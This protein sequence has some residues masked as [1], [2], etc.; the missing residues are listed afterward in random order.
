MLSDSTRLAIL[1]RLTQGERDFTMLARMPWNRAEPG[2]TECPAEPPH[3]GAR[4]THGRGP[5]WR[6]GI[7]GAPVR[8]DRRPLEKAPQETFPTGQSPDSLT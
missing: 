8:G 2:M 3:P 6:L 5:S 7:A 4:R 1:R